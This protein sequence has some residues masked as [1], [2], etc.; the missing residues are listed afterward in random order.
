VPQRRQR[1][2]STKYETIGMLSYQ[3]T[4]AWQEKQC[5]GG[6]TIDMPAGRRT[7]AHVGEAAEERAQHEGEGQRR[8]AVGEDLEPEVVR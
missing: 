7:D 6:R 4:G 2:R 5:E 8:G 3:A 1:P